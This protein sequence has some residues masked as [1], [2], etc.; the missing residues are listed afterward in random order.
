V[1]A[2]P[3]AVDTAAALLRLHGFLRSAAPEVPDALGELVVEV[4]LAELAGF[5]VLAD[6]GALDDGAAT[7]GVV[8]A[9][10]DPQADRVVASA[11]TAPAPGS[12]HW[13]RP[14]GVA[15]CVLRTSRRSPD[16]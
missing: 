1:T 12:G 10:V 14:S 6:L 7:A 2:L 5:D 16:R 4:G 8:G 13:W 11:R 3:S 9:V 15:R